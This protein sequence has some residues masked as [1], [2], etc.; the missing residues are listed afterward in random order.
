M[1]SA[2]NAN[3]DMCRHDVCPIITINVINWC[4]QCDVQRVREGENR[5]YCN[6]F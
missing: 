3:M 5:L 1:F 4:L 6:L 2:G